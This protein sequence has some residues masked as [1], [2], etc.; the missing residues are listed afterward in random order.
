VCNFNY[1]RRKGLLKFNGEWVLLYLHTLLF[2]AFHTFTC[3]KYFQKLPNGSNT[4]KIEHSFIYIQFHTALFFFWKTFRNAKSDP[5]FGHRGVI[6]VTSMPVKK[7]F[8]NTVPACI[9]LRR[10]Y[11][12]ALRCIPSQKYPWFHIIWNPSTSM[13]WLFC[14]V[15]FLAAVVA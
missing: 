3:H 6:L 13:W 9:L 8:R 12:M 11:G 1:T 14:I 7:R 10:S 5:K 4:C 2:S 15:T